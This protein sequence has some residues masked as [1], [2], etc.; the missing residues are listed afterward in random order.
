MSFVAAGVGV[1]GLGVAIYGGIKASKAQKKLEALQPPVYQPNKAISDYYQQALNKANSNP[2]QSQFYQ[3]AQKQANIAQGASIGALQDRRLA[4]GGIGALQNQTDQSMQ[5]AGVT[6]E[7]L[8]RQAFG[9]LGQATQ[10]KAGDD[11]TA[12]QYNQEAPYE[13]QLS[14][15]EGKAIAGSQME[16]AG[17]QTAFGGLSSMNQQRMMKSM[18]GGGG[19]RGGA[20]NSGYQSEGVGLADTGGP[21]ILN[22]Q[23]V[24]NNYPTLNP[25][26]SQF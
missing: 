25:A 3:Q 7:G 5:R 20:G 15:Y 19:S 1:A 2:Y 13:K 10:M 22:Q 4:L 18:Y 8:Q 14:I 16:N 9:Q 11:R 21:G 6:A 12:F 23:N 26:Y 24:S 17:I